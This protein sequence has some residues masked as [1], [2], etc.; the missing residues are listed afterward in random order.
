MGVN[1][2]PE[3]R[4]HLY[5]EGGRFSAYGTEYNYRRARFQRSYSC[6]DVGSEPPDLKRARGRRTSSIFS[7]TS[8][9][10]EFFTPRGSPQKS[11]TWRV[12]RPRLRYA[13]W[14]ILCV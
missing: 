5:V 10:N 8:S 1:A 14:I 7:S 13:F 2:R 3:E 11:L 6:E 4:R 12:N 9:V